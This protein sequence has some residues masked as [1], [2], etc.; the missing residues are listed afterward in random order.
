MKNWILTPPSLNDLT[1]LL[2][3]WRFWVLGALVGGLLGTAVYFIFPPAYRVR[4][5]VT[6]DFNVEQAWPNSPDSE[7]FYNLDRESRKLAEVAWSDATLQI[8]AIQLKTTVPALRAG[9]LEL[10]QPQDGIWQFYASDPQPEAAAILASTWAAAFTAQISRGIQT[11]IA[12]SV[13]RKALETSPND[14]EIKS[15]IEALEAKALGITPELQVSL[16]QSKDL[17][18]TRKVGPGTYVLAG[19]GVLLMLAALWILLF[20]SG[21][22]NA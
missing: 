9:Q 13:A 6:V 8:V 12:L 14:K 21:K 2:R 19:A 22:D 1:R 20:R 5:T 17:P 18:V 7:R 3:A 16:S 10:S 11:E 4:A 15:A